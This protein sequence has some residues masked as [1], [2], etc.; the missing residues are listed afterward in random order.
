MAGTIGLP[1]A[2]VTDGT[3]VSLNATGPSP[4]IDRWLLYVGA[5]AATSSTTISTQYVYGYNS[6]TDTDTGGF[7]S[8]NVSAEI[9]NL[10]W[11]TR[12]SIG[13]R[14]SGVTAYGAFLVGQIA[15]VAIWNKVLADNELL[16]LRTLAAPYVESARLVAYWPLLESPNAHPEFGGNLYNMT[17]VGDAA[18][19]SGAGPTITLYGGGTAN[20]NAPRA[21][22]YQ[23]LRGA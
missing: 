23:M 18:L 21:R 10:F 20:R 3:P 12:M 13:A 9:D 1:R 11:P 4:S 14:Q 6:A 22:Y 16:A 15:H 2:T 17:P 7:E 19:V 8:V 5:W